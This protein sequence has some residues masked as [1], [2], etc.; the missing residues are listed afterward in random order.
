MLCL[1]T[2]SSVKIP[3]SLHSSCVNG[4]LSK[5]IIFDADT[6]YRRHWHAI[7]IMILLLAFSLEAC[8]RDYEPI[9]N[10]R[11][12]MQRYIKNNLL[13][14]KDSDY[15]IGHLDQ[16][17]KLDKC[18]QPLEVFDSGNTRLI[19]HSTIGIRCRG[20]KMWQIYVPINI[21]RYTNVLVMRENLSRGSIL[22][23]SDVTT[24]RLDISRL[25]NGYFIDKNEIRGKVLKRSLRRGDILTDGMLA[26]RK[27]IK[28]GDIVTIMASSGTLAIRVKGE[29]LMDGRKGD[30]IRVKNHSSKREIQAV[31]VATGI[32]KV[33]M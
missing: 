23:A 19:G 16:R 5:E 21:I 32:V 15:E 24:R 4:L 6:F 33:N 28:R 26:V 27:L 29:A 10:I 11:H 14:D 2:A 25:S 12:T 13:Q 31:V 17:L 20:S 9:E 30:L 22:S 7:L 18:D 8:A 1:S 3:T